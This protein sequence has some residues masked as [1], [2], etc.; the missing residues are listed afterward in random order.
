LGLAIAQ[1]LAEATGAQ[2]VLARSAL[3]GLKVSI[4]WS[5]PPTS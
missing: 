5:P 4:V 3:G 2:I 1:D